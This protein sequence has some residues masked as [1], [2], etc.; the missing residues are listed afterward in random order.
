MHLYV[1]VPFCLR[2]CSYC[3]FAIAVRREVPSDDFVDAVRRERAIRAEAEGWDRTSFHTVYLGGGTPS[4]LSSSA[5]A[6]LLDPFPREPNAEVTLE[7]NPEDVT[8]DGARAWKAAGV[9]RVSLGVQSFDR[10]VLEWM[11][12]VH[13]G[14]RARR[15]VDT[16]RD[17]DLTDLSI[18]LIFALPAHLGHDL[19][20][21]LDAALAVGPPH[22]SA[23]GLTLEPRTPYARWV[24]RGANWPAGDDR[25]AAE[26]LLVHDR[27]TAAG[28]EHYEVS[29]FGLVRDG[30]AHRSRHNSAYWAGSPYVGLGPS[31]HGFR[32]GRR[33]WN[34]REW[35]DYRATVLG[36]HDPMAD[37]ERLTADQRALE[38]VYLGLRTA[39]GISPAVR[40][41]LDERALL[42]ATSA[43]W[44]TDA[45]GWLRPT[46]QG[47]L[48]M[49]QIATALTTSRQGG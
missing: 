35:V 39:D 18:D 20:R 12:R 33:R 21:D 36:G 19:A 11:H 47:W 41:M 4:R 26:F 42:A 3:D 23:Y 37:E 34:R 14:D 48:V 5:V 40:P 24:A 45:A 30:R 7:A 2:R 13:D 49:D 15:A 10:G 9:T 8:D 16:L 22:V 31:A 17:A 46:P 1:H 29:N 38:S 43:G 28:Y 6:R 27:L 44:L 32:E 25:F